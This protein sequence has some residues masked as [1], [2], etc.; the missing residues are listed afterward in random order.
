MERRQHSANA[1]S[2]N[3]RKCKFIKKNKIFL[4]ILDDNDLRTRFYNRLINTAD[5][6]QSNNVKENIRFDQKPL[7]NNLFQQLKKLDTGFKEKI[8]IQTKKIYLKA[9]QN[10]QTI[11][12]DLIPSTSTG[13]YTNTNTIDSD[14]GR[15]K[16]AIDFGEEIKTDTNTIKKKNLFEA[17][18]RV[19]RCLKKRK[20]FLETSKLPKQIKSFSKVNNIKKST[21]YS[22]APKKGQQLLFTKRN[23]ASNIKRVTIKKLESLSKNNNTK[24]NLKKENEQLNE[25]DDYPDHI[26]M[27]NNYFNN[28]DSS[29]SSSKNENNDEIDNNNNNYMNNFHHENGINNLLEPLEE[30]DEQQFNNEGKF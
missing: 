24:I 18:T 5:I 17:R 20:V 12:T 26:E 19:V 4:Y 6:H 25:I 28:H 23:A 30:F 15:P 1:K 29:L 10:N 16:S 21:N 13:S 14:S 9:N 3:K 2:T 8:P 27:Q 22:F 7:V 11:E